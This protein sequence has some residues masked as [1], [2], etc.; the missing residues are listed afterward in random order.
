MTDRVIMSRTPG[1]FRTV[2]LTARL[3]QTRMA[4][5]LE[6]AALSLPALVYPSVRIST[7]ARI[8]SYSSQLPGRSRAPRIHDETNR[9]FEIWALRSLRKK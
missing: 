3:K 7:L 4:S 1:A 6:I 5:G 9:F 2:L 8:S